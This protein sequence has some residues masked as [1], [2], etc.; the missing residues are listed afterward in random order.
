MENQPTIDKTNPLYPEL[1]PIVVPTEPAV[2]FDSDL[3]ALLLAIRRKQWDT[4]DAF[5]LAWRAAELSLDPGFGR[6]ICQ[7]HLQEHWKRVGMVPYP[8]QLETA[9]RV[10]K[11]MGGRAILADEVGLGKTIEAGLII[12]EY[13]LRGM[14]RRFLILV[15]AS[16]CMQWSAELQEKFALTTVIAKRSFE[17]SHYDY[18]IASLDTAK[19]PDN[20]EEILRRPFDLLVVDE[21]HKL[22]NTTTQ[23]WQF[24]NGLPKR[25]FLLLT[26]TPLQNDLK[27]LFN[28]ITLLRPGQLGTYRSFK[29]RFV[30]DKHRP[31]N[32]GELKGLLAEVMVRNRR[33]AAIQ[34]PPR[35]VENVILEPIAAER[36]LYLGVTEFVREEYRRTKG[37]ANL[38]PLITLQR[39]VCSSSFAAAVTLYKMCAGTNLE[40][41]ARL[42]EL[43]DLAQRIK[44]NAKMQQVLAIL[45]RADDKVII[46]TEFLATQAAIRHRLAQA[47]F[48]SLPFD[49]HMSGSKKD[50]MRCLFRDQP[51]CRVMVCTESGGEGL[52]FQFCHTLINYD[53]PWNPM[54]LEQRIGRVHRLG[55]VHPVTIYNLSTAGTVE[56]HLLVLLKEKLAMFQMVLGDLHRAIAKVAGDGG[57]ESQVFQIITGAESERDIAAG[58]ASLGDALRAAVEHPPEEEWEKWL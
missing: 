44:E 31:K 13:I 21:A 56:A 9:L 41:H 23:N 37:M 25:F 20:R 48:T 24:V 47:G 18:V 53:L 29:R 19:R 16:L 49:G 34:L 36:D 30:E 22:K 51:G 10:L 2:Q 52:N 1:P 57:F 6:L 55:Q 28:L 40:H 8:H 15:P 50:Y 4:W 43:L 45:A 35:R 5:T 3:R 46:F 33:S 7:P 42:L 58:F 27:E 32:A 38:L 54:R 26:A 12:K 17:F 39:E 11:Q 14:V